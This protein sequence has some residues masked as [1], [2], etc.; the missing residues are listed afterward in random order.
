MSS[1]RR[2]P[3]LYT[4]L[5]EMPVCNVQGYY[6]ESG[7]AGRDG[8]PAECILMTAPKDYPR[9]IQLL[10]KGGRAGRSKFQLGMDLLNQVRQTLG[11]P[12]APECDKS[13]SYFRVS[14]VHDP[15]KGGCLL[16][17]MS[18]VCLVIL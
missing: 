7:R 16:S 15:A 4:M 14:T 5:K 10:R 2:T 1:A 8:Q 3:L 11:K 13:P 18:H 9:L 12:W 6:Q 17:S